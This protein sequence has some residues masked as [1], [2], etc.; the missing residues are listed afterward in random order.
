MAIQIRKADFH[1]TLDD[2]RVWR[3]VKGYGGIYKVSYNGFVYS[4]ISD[5]YLK[6]GFSK[7]TGYYSVVLWRSNKDKRTH[8][9][10]RLVAEAFIANPE[11]KRT[12]NH[13]LC[14]KTLNHVAWLEWATHGENNKHAIDHGLRKVKCTP[15]IIDEIKRTHIKADKYFGATALAK[16]FNLST[17]TVHEILNNH[18]YKN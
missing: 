9:I 8:F 11:N 12:V 15:E 4:Y 14:H 2:P 16:K 10:H 18:V 5:K 6:P 3:D 7:G 1:H 13:V 17:C